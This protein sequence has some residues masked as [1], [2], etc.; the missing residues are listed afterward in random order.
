MQCRLNSHFIGFIER[1]RTTEMQLVCAWDRERERDANKTSNLYSIWKSNADLTAC[2]SL[3]LYL[4]L[5]M[6]LRISSSLLTTFSHLFPHNANCNKRLGH[7]LLQKFKYSHIF[8]TIYKPCCQPNM[9]RLLL[10]LPSLSITLSLSHSLFYLSLY[11]L[12]YLCSHFDWLCNC[13][14]FISIVQLEV[15]I[16]SFK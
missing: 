10:S 6:S 5:S 11:L 9:H 2:I 12:A 8:S 1:M 3:P 14:E 7:L 16:I 15:F 4:S 13:K